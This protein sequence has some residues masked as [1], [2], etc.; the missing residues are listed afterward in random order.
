MA[1]SI[2]KRIMILVDSVFNNS[3]INKAKEQIANE[4]F[5]IS[6]ESLVQRNTEKT[7]LLL[8]DKYTKAMTEQNTRRLFA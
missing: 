4:G 1:D 3:G 5:G 6:L 2:E 7:T 8:E